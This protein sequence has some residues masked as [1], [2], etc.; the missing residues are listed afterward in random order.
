MAKVAKLK[1]ISEITE[2]SEKKKPIAKPKTDRPV[3]PNT[4]RMGYLVHDVSRLR[5]TLFDQYMKPEG[6]T[7]SQW[8]V[9]ANLSRHNGEGVVSTELAKELY[10]GKVTMS[11]L[12]ER[13]EK[14]GYIY[15]RADKQDRRAKQIFISGAGYGLIDRM[16]VIT[17][18]LNKK[19]CDGFSQEDIEKTEAYLIHLK[20][21]VLLLLNEFSISPGELED[22]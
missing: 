5:R 13:L 6:I 9:L 16:K 10:V 15:R 20:R 19:I 22:D 3:A 17:E 7:R 1:V 21:N 14:A 2:K 11:F 18:E 4:F 12:I 8:W